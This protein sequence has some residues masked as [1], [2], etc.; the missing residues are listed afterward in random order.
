MSRG[1][2]MLRAASSREEL[3][4][5]RIAGATRHGKRPPRLDKLKKPLTPTPLP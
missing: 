5:A 1:G 4:Y 3:V 2:L